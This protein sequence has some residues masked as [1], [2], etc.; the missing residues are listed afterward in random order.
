MQTSCIARKLLLLSLLSAGAN[1]WAADGPILT[2]LVSDPSGAMIPGVSVVLQG[3]NQG[4]QQSSLTNPEGLYRFVNLTPGLYQLQV[5]QPGFLPFRQANLD[6]ETGAERRLDI[7]LQLA[8]QSETMTVTDSGV[9]IETNSSQAGETINSAKLATV[10]L[11]GRSFTD[12]LALQPGVIPAPSQ[13]PNAVVMAGVTSTPPSGGLNPGNLSVS[14]QRETANGFV[15]NGSAVEE[16]VNMGSAI[17][18]TLD[19]IAEFSVLTNNFNA[20]YG[21]YS[22]GQ[23]LVVTKSGSDQWH[24]SAFDF[25]RNTDLDAR[26]FFSSQRASFDQNQFGGTLGGPIRHDR[27]FFFA[28]YQDSQMTQ[29]IDTGLIH[30]PSLQD[31]TGNLQDVEQSLTGTVKGQYW[32]NLLSQKLGYTIAPNEPYYIAGCR[33]NV[34]CVFPNAIIPQ[35]AWSAPAAAL[36]NYIPVPDT[37]SAFSSAASD[38]QLGDNKG[39]LRVD[40]NTRFGMLSAYYFADRYSLNNPYP[41][42]QGGANVPGL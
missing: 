41:T 33:S 31:R 2:G 42:G 32:A 36:L 18:P 23:I 28:D 38:E 7:R 1:T 3:A 21:N 12:L 26:N 39:S 8:A 9:S 22:G 19:S 29:G 30:V 5:Q 4:L 6:L 35:R 25:L 37:G 11:N 27:I 14:G 15:V 16:T 20:E 17:I 24:G 34:Q 13:Q 40:G 10:P